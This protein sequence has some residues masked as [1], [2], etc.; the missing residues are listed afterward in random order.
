MKTDNHCRI[1]N[2]AL[3]WPLPGCRGAA[4]LAALALLPGSGLGADASRVTTNPGRQFSITLDSNPTTGYQWKLAKPVTGTCVALVTNEFV[5]PKS[6]MT[7]APGK[8]VWKFKALS[9][10][11]LRSNC[12]MCGPG[13][14]ESSRRGRQTSQSLSQR[15]SAPSDTTSA[16]EGG[17]LK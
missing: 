17:C 12:S 1:L 5:R 11:R 10:G 16:S 15:G 7:G 9:R 2:H 8:E 13:T 4:L 14:R 3:N 6:K